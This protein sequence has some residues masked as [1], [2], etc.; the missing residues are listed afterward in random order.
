MTEFVVK[1]SGAREQFESGMVRDTE[2]GKIDYTLILDGPMLDRWA[3]HLTK[4]ARKYAPRNWMRATGHEEYQ[5]FLRSALR[6]FLQ[7]IRGER[8]EDHAAGVFF[9][10][11]GAEY[12]LSQLPAPTG[13]DALDTATKLDMEI[14]RRIARMEIAM[15]KS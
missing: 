3:D 11:N 8:D 9:N 7:W 1:D 4:G 15:G 10:I 6:H 13:R 12:V 2:D 5:R 14:E